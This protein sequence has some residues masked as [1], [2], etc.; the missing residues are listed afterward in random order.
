VTRE[1]QEEG[2]SRSQVKREFRELKELG[3]QLT[4]LTSGQLS[5]I[6]LSGGLRDAVLAAKQMH[7][8]ARQ[9]QY[10]FISSLLV[11]EDVDAIRAALAGELQPHAEEVA[12]I[13][14]A[15]RWRDGLLSS[16]E[17]KLTAFIEQYPE[18]DRTHLRQLVRNAKKELELEKPPKSAR[19]LFRYIRQL[20][21]PM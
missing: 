4:A 17:G 21:G 11:D 16:D 2:K 20:V 5:A 19:Q 1:S 8:N 18:C 6:P 10:R 3:V 13:H 9:R 15:K 14:E 7:R 12:A